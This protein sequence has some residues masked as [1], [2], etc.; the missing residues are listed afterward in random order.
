MKSQARYRKALFRFFACVGTMNRWPPR[1]GRKAPINRTHSKRFA[2]A[3]PSADDASAFGVRAT[4]APLAQGRLGFADRADSWKRLVTGEIGFVSSLIAAYSRTL[5]IGRAEPDS[6][7]GP[8]R[9]SFVIG[10]S[11]FVPVA[12]AAPTIRSGAVADLC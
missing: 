7:S 2:L 12:S 3:A 11:S 8:F 4:S 1:A 10:H 9:H 5:L 6:H